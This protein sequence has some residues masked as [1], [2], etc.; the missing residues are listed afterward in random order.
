MADEEIEEMVRRLIE[1]HLTEDD[2]KAAL[3]W[4]DK[5]IIRLGLV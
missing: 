1:E 2:R 5:R 3:E 4:L